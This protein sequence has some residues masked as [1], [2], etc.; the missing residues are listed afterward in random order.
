MAHISQTRPHEGRAGRDQLGWS[1]R[2][3]PTLSEFRAQLIAP[4]FRLSAR[5]AREVARHAFGEPSN[6]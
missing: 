4:R 5:M 1:S 6:D 3:A 2:S